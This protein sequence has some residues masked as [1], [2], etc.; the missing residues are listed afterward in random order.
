MIS[1][2]K[3]QM[4]FIYVKFSQ[5]ILKDNK[6]TNISWRAAT[7]KGGEVPGEPLH[8]IRSSETT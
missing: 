8:T 2:G 6:P 1:L 4:Q 5:S 7:A 3:P